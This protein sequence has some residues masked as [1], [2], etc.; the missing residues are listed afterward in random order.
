MPS[1]AYMHNMK[2]KL[3]INK[4]IRPEDEGNIKELDKWS[5]FYNTENTKKRPL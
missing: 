2:G 3:E 1:N 4:Y 5:H